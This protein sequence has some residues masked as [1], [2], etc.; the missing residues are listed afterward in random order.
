[1]RSVCTISRCLAVLRNRL[2]INGFVKKLSLIHFDSIWVSKTAEWSI[3]STKTVN[4][5]YVLSV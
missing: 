2:D 5:I 3:I 1:M 4:H